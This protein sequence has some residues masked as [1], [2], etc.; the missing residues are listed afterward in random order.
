MIKEIN[1]SIN[2]KYDNKQREIKIMIGERGNEWIEKY[3]NIQR[4]K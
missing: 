3:N 1:E 4:D 2:Q